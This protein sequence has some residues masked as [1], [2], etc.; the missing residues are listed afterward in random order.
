MNTHEIYSH[1]KIMSKCRKALESIHGRNIRIYLEVGGKF[2]FRVPGS[3]LLTCCQRRAMLT[4]P[5]ASRWKFTRED[6]CSQ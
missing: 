6:M 1:L 2:G 4:N 3:Y 5:S